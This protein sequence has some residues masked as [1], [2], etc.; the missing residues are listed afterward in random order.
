MLFLNLLYRWVSPPEYTLFLFATLAMSCT[1]VRAR[2]LE[3]LL[4]ISTLVI[5][6]K[7]GGV[8]T[9]CNL[10]CLNDRCTHPSNVCR[11]IDSENL[12]CWTGANLACG[13]VHSRLTSSHEYAF[14]AMYREAGGRARFRRTKSLKQIESRTE[15]SISESVSWSHA[16]CDRRHVQ[17]APA[18][19]FNVSDCAPESAPEHTQYESSL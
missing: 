12:K 8:A 4:D 13:N 15:S 5:L 3:I 1:N 11:N 10:K 16:I 14:W 9:L 17:P 2:I 18:N 19:T 7:V 6:N